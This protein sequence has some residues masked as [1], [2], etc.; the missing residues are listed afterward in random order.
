MARLRRKGNPVHGWIIVDKPEGVTST[1]VVA[2]VK[3]A[4]GAAKAGHGGTLD[5]IATGVLP[6]ALGEA[7]KTVAYVVDGPKSYRFT[8]RWGVATDTDDAEGEVIGE[9]P[10]RPNRAAI[11]AVLSEFIG[12]IEQVPPVFSAVKVEGKRAYELA[13][14]GAPVSLPPRRVV[15]ERVALVALP[16]RDHAEFEVTCGKG[17]YM[18]ALARDIARR[19]G[20]VGHV[21]ALRRTRVGP[22]TEENAISLDDL[23][24]FG[25]IS[26]VLE[27]LLPVETALDDIPALAVTEQEAGRL[28]NGQAVSLL[29]KVDL[30]RIAAL[31][32]GDTVLALTMGKPVALTRYHAG[33]VRPVR[34]LNL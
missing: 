15:I 6:V 33:E 10:E 5:P 4:T 22:F 31:E 25:Q 24:A 23:C 28:R 9:S 16:D 14:A 17:A 32:D 18:R 2:A 21:A 29:R 20:T 13:R 30:D 27:H 7:T 26:A 34:V 1:A 8:L 3:R 19:L 11:E 12:E